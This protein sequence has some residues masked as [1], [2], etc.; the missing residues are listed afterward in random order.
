MH[1]AISII[2][3]TTLIGVGQGLFLALYTGQLY[4]VFRL[5][6]AQ[7]SAHFYALGSLLALIFL[8]TGLASSFFH[9]GRPDRAWRSAARWR[10][11]WMSREVIVLP[12]F[13]GAV[14]V[15]GLIH[16]TAWNPVLF[17]FRDTFAV[18]L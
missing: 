15:W 17:T 6:P 8:V 10:T 9:L 12:A 16:F 13:M 14:A 1:P 4:S 2:F 18:D 11:S 7:E 5:L 3:L